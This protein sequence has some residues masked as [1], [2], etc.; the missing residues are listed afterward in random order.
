[1]EPLCIDSISELMLD[2]AIEH[3]LAGQVRN[4]GCEIEKLRPEESSRY[5]RH[6]KCLFSIA[7]TRR[8]HSTTG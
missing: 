4:C 5:F 3:W 7:D 1:M 2:G 6:N 8:H